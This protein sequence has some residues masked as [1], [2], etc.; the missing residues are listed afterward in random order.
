M[1]IIL[2]ILANRLKLALLFIISPEQTGF[3]KDRNI[4][5]GIIITSE[6]IHSIKLK[7]TRGVILKLDFEKAFDTVNWD[8]LFDVLSRMNFGSRWIMWMRSIFKTMKITVLINGSSTNEFSPSRGLRQGDQ[9]SPLLFNL[10]GQ[11]LHHL[12]NTANIHGKFTG[13]QIG[14]DGMNFTHL[15]F[16]D[17]T[18]LFINGD[19]TSIYNVKSI[20]ITFQLL[21]GLCINFSKSELLAL[22]YDQE[23]Q[24]IWANKLGC[25][26][27][28][29]PLKYLGVPLGISQKSKELR[30]PL[31][32]NF[33]NKLNNW[34]SVNLNM[35][36]KLTL[37][38]A[39]L[40]SL[41]IHWFNFFHMPVGIR[42]KIDMIRRKFLWGADKMHLLSWHRVLLDKKH[43]GLGI[44]NLE[45]RNLDM[46]CWVKVGGTFVKINNPR[47]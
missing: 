39:T 41:P 30:E 45:H 12:I 24:E 9:L 1:K 35:A 19:D 31:V 46:F 20:L 36:G 17:D 2:K 42:N 4:S 32:Q 21:F 16:A 10:V 47:G 13:I 14:K 3:M 23:Q 33:N 37:M 38:K 25:R 15:Q 22:N 34:L 26:V 27:G 43:R 8:F 29:W 5:D 28:N 40:D 6:I 44:T 7:K 18:L 11:I